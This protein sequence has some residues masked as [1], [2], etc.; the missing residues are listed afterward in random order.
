MRESQDWEG[1][2]IPMHGRIDLKGAWVAL[3][4]AF[5]G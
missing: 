3:V 1:W 2:G 4:V 5:R